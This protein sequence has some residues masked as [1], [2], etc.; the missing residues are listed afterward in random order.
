MNSYS[1]FIGQVTAVYFDEHFIPVSMFNDSLFGGGEQ[2]GYLLELPETKDLQCRIKYIGLFSSPEGR[3]TLSIYSKNHLAKAYVEDTLALIDWPLQRSFLNQNHFVF[4]FQYESKEKI[5]SII[6]LILA[7]LNI[8]NVNDD[9]VNFILQALHVFHDEYIRGEDKLTKKSIKKYHLKYTDYPETIPMVNENSHEENFISL[10]KTGNTQN[11]I[12]SLRQGLDPN[13]PYR[14][15]IKG[16]D[17]ISATEL[18]LNTAIRCAFYHKRNEPT[19]F[20]H[21]NTIKTLLSYG[22]NPSLSDGDATPEELCV[23][24]TLK[25]NYRFKESDYAIIEILCMLMSVPE[26][27]PCGEVHP[28]YMGTLAGQLIIIANSFRIQNHIIKASM[29]D[30]MIGLNSRSVPIMT[31][32]TVNNQSIR[33][34]RRRETQTSR[35]DLLSPEERKICFDLFQQKMNMKEKLAQEE[36]T[37]LFRGFGELLIDL[38]QSQGI[39]GFNMAEN[40]TCDLAEGSIEIHH[41]LLSISDIKCDRLMSM[42]SFIEPFAMKV[43]NPALRHFAVWEAATTAS[44][45]Q[46]A[47][48]KSFSPKKDIEPNIMAAI[49]NKL[50]PANSVEL[51]ELYAALKEPHA[52][53][54]KQPKPIGFFK[55]A[56]LDGK[57]QYNYTTMVENFFS[58]QFGEEGESPIIIFEINEEALDYFDK[59]ISQRINGKT[60]KELVNERAEQLHLNT[61][62]QPRYKSNI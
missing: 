59:V 3:V 41:I 20:R 37:K 5:A 18:P 7:E 51:H 53:F 6:K 11:I 9:V 23:R 56:T 21:F 57:F 4:S 24:M 45:N 13:R 36:F 25:E 12:N 29:N 30:V 19:L 61:V 58:N 26:S 15:Y 14:D 55:D 27:K 50:Y 44:I 46:I 34:E 10:I 49:L 38:I 54:K 43:Q 33:I 42:L 2:S 48:L 16:T 32:T 39:K 40:L 17:V 35:K 1:E 22:A 62:N 60:F 47:G 31:V 8:F 28:R 52:Q